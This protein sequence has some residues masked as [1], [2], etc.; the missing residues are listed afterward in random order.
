MNQRGDRGFLIRG[1]TLIELLIVMTIIGILAVALLPQVLGVWGTANINVTAARLGL[2][3]TMIE[4]YAKEDGDFPP[5]EFSKRRRDVKCTGD[6]T[7]AGI[8]CMLIHL[9]NVNL[10]P[11]LSF[12]DKAQ[13]LGNTDG[14]DNKFIIPQLRTTK[15]MEVLDAWL[16]PIVYFHNSSYTKAQAIILGGGDDEGGGEEVSV[17][18]MKQDG[19]YAN[20]RKYQLISAGKDQEFGTSDDIC[21]PALVK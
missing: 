5:S 4:K 10:G 15:K 3:Q 18:A 21:Y 2:L 13:W 6:T 14:D 9:G 7:N 12:D 11:S 17:R 1:F 8:E 20:P 19:E 16:N